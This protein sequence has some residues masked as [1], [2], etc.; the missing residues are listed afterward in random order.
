MMV[1]GGGQP[2][3]GRLSGDGGQPGGGR[4]L[5]GLVLNHSCDGTRR[6]FDLFARYTDTKLFFLDT[7]RKT[8]PLSREYLVGQYRKMARWLQDLSGEALTPGRVQDSI[9]LFNENYRLLNEIR[10][11]WMKHPESCDAGEM[12]RLAEIFTTIPREQ[13][14]ELLQEKLKEMRCRTGGGRSRPAGLEGG[15]RGR[16]RV[17][18][19]G[20]IFDPVPLF[21]AI[22]ESGGTVAG[23]DFCFGGRY[24]PGEV[25]STSSF[26]ENLAR[27][28]LGRVGCGRMENYRD[29]F[30]FILR[31]MQLSGATG[32]IYA[33]V[34]FCDSFL[35]DYPLLRDLLEQ[36]GIPSLLIEGEYFSLG[37]GQIRTRVEA[38]IETLREGEDEASEASITNPGSSHEWW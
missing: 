22:S 32:L 8:D 37:S 18:V 11:M 31:G 17:F 23:D 14:A 24:R 12:V 5:A 27:Y 38:F 35:M 7:P 34:K 28:A 15:P 1:S 3:G 6:C 29:R 21:Q 33:S 4:S 30:D 13:A 25:E 16:P 9:R 10:H 20:N 19:S 26:Y 36:A 2:G